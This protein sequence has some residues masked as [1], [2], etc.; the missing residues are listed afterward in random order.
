MLALSHLAM[1]LLFPGTLCS[2]K[3]EKKKEGAGLPC[4]FL[5]KGMSDWIKKEVIS[6][7]ILI[8]K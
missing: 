8:R 5:K 6:K 4:G 7:L 3:K 1:F 2:K